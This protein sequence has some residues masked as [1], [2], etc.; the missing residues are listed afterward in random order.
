MSEHSPPPQGVT[1]QG[2][3][4]H[5]KPFTAP[6]PNSSIDALI[7]WLEVQRND[8][9]DRP[10]A[11]LVDSDSLP[12]ETVLELAVVDLIGQ[13]RRG[14]NA[15]PEDYLMQ[16]P[17][18]ADSRSA[19]LD[20]IDAELCVRRELGDPCEA[21]FFIKRFPALADPIR[22]LIYLE[23]QPHA[24]GLA[25]PDAAVS[26]ARPRVSDA[27]PDPDVVECQLVEFSASDQFSVQSDMTVAGLHRRQ[28]MPADE[29]R[30]DDSIDIPI[31]IK[32]PEWVTGA[33]C[34][35]TT[36]TQFGRYWLVK[37]RDSQRTDTVAMKIIPAPA[38]LDRTQRT[39]ILDL[40]E[41]CSNVTHPTWVAPRIAAINNGHLAV[42]RPWIFGV[43]FTSNHSGSELSQRLAVLVR[44]AFALSA[45]HR[46]G[47]THGSLKPNNIIIDHQSN[48]NLIDA[49]SG[50]S[51]WEDYLCRWD[52]DLSR[53][54]EDRIRA[55]SAALLKLVANECIGAGNHAAIDWI[56]RINNEVD[57]GL[58]DACVTIGE[59]LQSLLDQA[60]TKRS[61][62]RKT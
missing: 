5:G 2:T 43:A 4:P 7:R 10:L 35:A 40:C 17:D 3:T 49:G 41:K 27:R 22:Q 62:W 45:A 58:A 34:I 19:V 11:D 48:V 56:A 1:P 25:A 51:A 31:P 24:P 52:N 39:R 60:P 61:W 29:I 59:A 30:K 53:S 23:Y 28:A 57:F 46:I 50:V 13:R 20:L 14:R 15:L 33:R 54:L 38:V 16:F 26:P 42:V 6:T 47:A 55:D 44:V 32:P 12:A 36:P 9:P 18:L 8:H 37:G 21:S